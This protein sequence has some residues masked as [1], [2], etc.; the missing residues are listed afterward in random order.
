VRA[1]FAARVGVESSVFERALLTKAVVT[2]E[3][4]LEA[5]KQA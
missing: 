2:A 1:V 4:R 3:R 5:L